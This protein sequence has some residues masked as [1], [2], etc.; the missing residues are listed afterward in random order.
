MFIMR[1]L[2]MLSCWTIYANAQLIS[3][4]SERFDFIVDWYP[5][6]SATFG[7]DEDQNLY[8]LIDRE[9]K[10]INTGD[11]NQ[12]LRDII[13]VD[14]QYFV[15]RELAFR[16]QVLCQIVDQEIVEVSDILPLNPDEDYH[17]IAPYFDHHSIILGVLTPE[18][19][20]STADRKS[21]IYLFDI[22]DNCF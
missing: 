6:P 3:Y 10:L 16:G 12:A 1:L 21:S 8:Q 20:P 18:F 14:S 7:Y 13:E 4:Q 9:L 22:K 5:L 2:I 15:V 11:F 19:Y 17:L